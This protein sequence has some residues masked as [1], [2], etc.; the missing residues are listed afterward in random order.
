MNDYGHICLFVMPVLGL[1]FSN[2]PV[3]GSHHIPNI[4]TSLYTMEVS[5]LSKT[6]P[7]P[8]KDKGEKLTVHKARKGGT[9]GRKKGWKKPEGKPKRPLSAY[10][11]FFQQEKERVQRDGKYGFAALARKIAE[12]WNTLDKEDKSPYEAQAAVEK[13]KYVQEVN[14]WK[15]QTQHTSDM[16]STQDAD[17][18]IFKSDLPL[19]L[20]NYGLGNLASSPFLPKVTLL[21]SSTN[22]LTFMLAGASG[23]S[24]HITAP[25]TTSF[26]FKDELDEV[27]SEISDDFVTDAK[28]SFEPLPL[29]A[30]E[31]DFPLLS[32]SAAS[33]VAPD[34][35][36]SSV[37]DTNTSN[38]ES[39][40]VKKSLQHLASVMDDECFD[41]M[42]SLISN[43]KSYE[44]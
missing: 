31:V 6:T 41:L 34:A 39:P 15:E 22:A 16:L 7:I 43:P 14:L 18:P 33:S 9:P 35:C 19:N 11:L 24:H 5:K 26:A 28:Q 42:R 40:I 38:E 36:V 20:T 3:F 13:A 10:N 30:D 32:L 4:S 21:G 44:I 2:D 37:S 17:F 23:V 12:K 1:T 8:T 25:L 29:I 27:I